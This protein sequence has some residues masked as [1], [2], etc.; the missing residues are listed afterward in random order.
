M[1]DSIKGSNQYGD[2]KFVTEKSDGFGSPSYERSKR[3]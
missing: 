3:N 2:F 1:N